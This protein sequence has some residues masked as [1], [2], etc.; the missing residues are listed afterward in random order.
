M[1]VQDSMPFVSLLN[2]YSFEQRFLKGILAQTL[3]QQ[4]K[5]QQQPTCPPLLPLAT[6]KLAI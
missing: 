5:W 6:M 2:Q 1:Y 4:H 3:L